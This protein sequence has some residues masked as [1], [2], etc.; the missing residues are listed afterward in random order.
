MFTGSNVALATPFNEQGE[1]DFSALHA[2]V[3]FHL[4]HGTDGLVVAGT[5]GESAALTQSEFCAML[6]SVVEQVSGRIPVIA[7]TGSASTQRTLEQTRLAAA[8]GADAALVV[9]P[10]YVRPPQRGLEAHYR[11]VADISHIPVIVYNVPSRTAVDILPATVE[12]LSHHQNIVGIKEA[13]SEVGRVVELRARCDDSFTLLSGD[14]HSC[15]QAMKN[16]ANGVI[17]VAANL[18]P[19]KMAEMCRAARSGD[20]AVAKREE[21]SLKRLFDILMIESNPIPVKWSLFEMKLIGPHIRLPLTELGDEFREPIRQCLQELKL[22]P[23]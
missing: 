23:A 4:E 13:V 21:S 17:S 1:I 18:V 5:T 2:L 9:T 7:G 22:I 20:W 6:E 16:G 11:A 3:N 10:Y 8:H 12:K 14:D 15:L 19:A